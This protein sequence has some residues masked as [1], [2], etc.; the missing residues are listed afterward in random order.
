MQITSEYFNK[1]ISLKIVSGHLSS[2]SR[3][4]QWG[5]GNNNDNNK[6]SKNS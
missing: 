3:I 6:M 1:I 5:F 2:N 4:Q